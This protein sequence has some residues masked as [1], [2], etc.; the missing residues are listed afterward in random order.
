MP[1]FPASNAPSEPT[2]EDLLRENAELRRQVEELRIMRADREQQDATLRLQDQV[3][4]QIH[5]SVV[6]TDLDGYVTLWNNGASRIFGFSADE[7][8]GRH[9]SFVY[10]PEDLPFLEHEVIA[11][12]RKRGNHE[13]EVRMRRTGGEPLY[14]HLSLSLLRDHQ[15]NAAGMIGYSM[16][17]TDRKRAEHELKR[18]QEQLLQLVALR[19]TELSQA[20]EQLAREIAERKH[21][22]EEL[23]E[24]ERRFSDILSTISL[25]AVCLD[26]CG[27]I[28]FCNDYLLELTGWGRHEIMGR[29]W[30]DLFIPPECR[31]GLRHKFKT[32]FSSASFPP[33]HENEIITREGERRTITWSNT[34]LRDCS[35]SV[36]GTASIGQDISV[37]KHA[38]EALRSQAELIELTHDSIMVYGLDE[39]IIFWNRGAEQTFGWS[40]TEA[41]GKTV[42][43]LLETA[44]PI[45][46]AKLWEH[47]YSTGH[48]EGELVQTRRDG[49]KLVVASRWAVQRDTA[50]NPVAILE[51]SN[52]ITENREAVEAL[53]ES[54]E[55]L[56][57]SVTAGNTGTWEWDIVTGHET[58]SDIC[59]QIFGLTPE[60]FCENHQ[61]FV[62]LILPQDL[63]GQRE[64]L[65]RAVSQRA[66]YKHEYRIRR[67]DGIVRWVS[68][69]GK[70][71]YD[72]AGRPVRMMGVVSDITERKH[73]EEELFKA[74]KLESIGVLAGGIAHDFNNL[75]TAILGNITLARRSS[76]R[77]D[78]ITVLLSEA[79][80]GCLNAKSLTNQLLT[81]SKG[82]APIRETASIGELVHETALFILRGSPVS[83]EFVIPD[84]LPPVEV[85]SGQISQVLQNIIINAVQAM[86]VPGTVTISA[87][88]YTAAASGLKQTIGRDYVRVSIRD[89]GIGIPE[90][91]LSRIFDPF[92][93]TK[94]NGTGLGLASSYSIMAHHEGYIEVESR[95][96]AGTTFHLFLPVAGGVATIPAAEDSWWSAPPGPARILVMDDDRKIR[97]VVER[98]LKSAGY[99]AVAVGTG[100]AAVERYRKERE[101]GATFDAVIM[102]LTVQGGM[103]GKEAMERLLEI[104]PAVTA[105]VSSGYSNDP[106]MAN[107]RDYGFQAVLAKPYQLHDLEQVLRR[108]VVADT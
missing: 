42:S 9:I 35:G 99:E 107:Y 44:F 75:L 21:A 25:L 49:R 98:F 85:D 52:D 60:T 7:A 102:D 46:A 76:P 31:D 26:S 34:T 12:L 65:D 22:E 103:G 64:A 59:H 96:G 41:I 3:I 5:D 36:I 55:R 43:E 62:G 61:N 24:S 11:P 97:T 90:E 39:Q 6:A 37:R 4:A 82:G 101:A 57:L 28:T 88:R 10:F 100:E 86:P 93:T 30:F 84:D 79:E 58:W 105:I 18:Y 77:D 14:A 33:H 47:L 69:Q 91:N 53:R 8:L 83:C 27:M 23:H 106:V 45:E 78:E 40:K 80:K 16:D 38:E 51:I 63:P 13:I 32:A 50:G 87:A 72:D 48:W 89:N 67:P 94:E 108:I 20:N 2:I 66:D 15:G 29:N 19:T 71:Y 74:Q 95:P 92:F 1:D 104:D 73:L 17:I 81:F 68:A 54:E 56:K 70:C